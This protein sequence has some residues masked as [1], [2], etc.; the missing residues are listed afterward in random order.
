MEQ[1]FCN[2]KVSN[3]GPASLEDVGEY[4]DRGFCWASGDSGGMV[5][6][7]IIKSIIYVLYYHLVGLLWYKTIDEMK[8]DIEV[9]GVKR[10]KERKT[11]V[12]LPK[13]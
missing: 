7:I 1:W 5:A 3:A 12:V 6:Q 8:G 9:E 13:L 2:C 10:T 11:R 4:E